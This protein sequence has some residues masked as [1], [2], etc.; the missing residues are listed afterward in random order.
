M[1]VIILS[2]SVNSGCL[3]ASNVV[4]GMSHQP[5]K[6]NP[7]TV[8]RK[9]PKIEQEENPRATREAPHV[10]LRNNDMLINLKLFLI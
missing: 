10:A 9:L 3:A 2:C 6:L 4:F 5:V 7:S 1:N 8:V